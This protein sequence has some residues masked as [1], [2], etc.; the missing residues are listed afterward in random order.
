MTNPVS[1]SVYEMTDEDRCEDLRAQASLRMS[2]F[3]VIASIAMAAALGYASYKLH[4]NQSLP[5]TAQTGAPPSSSWQ[6]YMVSL[7]YILA[8]AAGLYACAALPYSVNA[9]R[10]G[11]RAL[12]ERRAAAATRPASVEAHN[13]PPAKP[14]P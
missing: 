13:A 4:I 9:F 10:K 12:V 7:K 8:G 14:K 11:A 3:G 5:V 1:E 2:G 6:L